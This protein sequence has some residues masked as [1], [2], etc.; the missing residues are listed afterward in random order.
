M[1]LSSCSRIGAGVGRRRSVAHFVP[2]CGDLAVP[3]GTHRRVGRPRGQRSACVLRAKSNVVLE[4]FAPRLANVM[5]TA[6]EKK[7]ATNAYFMLLAPASPNNVFTAA[8]LSSPSR[9]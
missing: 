2:A 4:E 1:P 3:V 6:V 9:Q 8:S 7:A 5:K